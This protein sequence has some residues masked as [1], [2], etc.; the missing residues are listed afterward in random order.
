EETDVP[1]RKKLMKFLEDYGLLD[2][3]TEELIKKV[4]KLRNEIAHGKL[5]YKDLHNWPLPAFL[6]I[7]NSTAYNLLYEIQI[8]SARA[9][10]S[11]I[12]ISLWERAWKEIHNGLPFS[13]DVYSNI[14]EEYDT[15]NF[16]Y[17]K[18]KYKLNLENLFEF[19]L[20]NHRRIS[21]NKMEN[22]F[23]E[24]VFNEGVIAD[25]EVL[26]LVSIILTD[27]KNEK[28][29]TNA[30]QKFEVLY[31]SLEVTSFS[32]IKDIYSYMLEY[33]IV[34]KWLYSWLKHYKKE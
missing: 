3:K 21:I 16:L 25:E 24:F 8:L 20:N 2:K 18:D 22:I 6:N 31:K 15:F 30:K 34:L 10:S 4:I 14:I 19:Y 9:I 28:V 11:F 29:S 1:I 13:I 12:G 7:T 23:Y 5:T 17:L 33:G 32:N 27:S 26:L